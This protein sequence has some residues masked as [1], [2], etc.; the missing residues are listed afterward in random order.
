MTTESVTVQLPRET[1]QCFRRGAGAAGKSL[2]QFLAD[3]LMDAVPPLP[4]N[5][6][7]AVRDE[8]DAMEQLDDSALWEVAETHLS[9]SQQ[10]LYSRLLGKTYRASADGARRLAH[11]VADEIIEA[12]TG[13]KGIF[14]GRLVLVGNRTG[15]KELY[16]CDSDGQGLAQL[17]RDRSISL[18]P[19]WSADGSIISYTSYINGFPDVYTIDVASG[20]RSRV[21]SFPGLNT[22]GEI[23][24]NGRDMA[25]ILSKDGNP[26]LYVMD[27]RSRRLTRITQTPR[28]AEASPSWS[29]DG[30]QIVY[31]SDAP[32]SP[33]LYV[34]SR[35][36][37]QPKRLTGRVAESVTPR[38]GSNG[39]ITYSA[40]IGGRYH[41]CVLNPQTL[42]SR[43][44]TADGAD[45][46]NPCWAPNG[47][48]IACGRKTGGRSA[49]YLL[50][51]MG[52]PPIALLD[53]QGNWYSPSWSAQ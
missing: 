14:S 6:P 31:V 51:T 33:Q 23:S 48:H 44:I 12:V 5:I 32:G 22:G 21:A 37:G 4:E 42:E 45:Y 15:S 8:L 24:P 47:R 36:G 1:L 52:D 46:E 50:D 27:L 17:T 53:I 9:P 41:V 30:S 39:V 10:R 40:R 13:Q 28:A 20:S 34:V 25:L 2:E 3:R 38:W 11:Q 7:L 16:L 18:A 35:D 29:P 49:I 26:E 19:R 43:Q